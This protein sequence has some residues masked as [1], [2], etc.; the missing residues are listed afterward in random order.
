MAAETAMVRIPPAVGMHGLRAGLEYTGSVG[1][2]RDELPARRLTDAPWQREKWQG[3]CVL[4]RP[5][6]RMFGWSTSTGELF[7]ASQR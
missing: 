5:H 3:K 1:R 2:E 7:L 6:G 4:L